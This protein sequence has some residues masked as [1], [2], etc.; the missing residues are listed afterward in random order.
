MALAAWLPISPT[1]ASFVRLMLD[2][3]ARGWLFGVLMLAGF[4]SPYLFGLAVFVGPVFCSATTARRLLRVPIALMHSQLFLVALVVWQHGQAAA[5]GAMLGFSVV[6]GAYLALYSGKTFASGDGPSMTWYIRWGSMVVT[7]IAA[8][9][10]LQRSV[11]VDL[12]IGLHVVLVL[13][14]GMLTTL[15]RTTL[16]VRSL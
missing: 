5:A 15:R 11:G 7:A 2:E 13:A 1:G 3:F 10:E 6:S 12:D 16:I 4:G 9:A 14:L 8:W